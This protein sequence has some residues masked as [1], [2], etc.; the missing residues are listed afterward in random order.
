MLTTTPNID[1]RSGEATLIVTWPDGHISTYAWL[2]LRDCCGCD[3]CRADGSRQRLT[4]VASLPAT[5][6]PAETACQG[7]S[8]VV[9]W[10]P[11]RHESRHDLAWLRRNCACGEHEA[12]G[13]PP[14]KPWRAG[15]E[16]V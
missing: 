9:S 12:Y 15:S 13:P 8:L 2:W 7:R 11:D 5:P 10:E 1:L 14:R 3:D 6:R 4:D 16:G